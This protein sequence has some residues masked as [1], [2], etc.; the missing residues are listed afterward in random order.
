MILK[1]LYQELRKWL[2]S[3]EGEE[4][5]KHI[6]DT[7]NKIKPLPRGYKVTYKDSWCAT[8]VSFIFYILGIG[9]FPF[10]CSCNLMM[11]AAKKRGLWEENDNYL[12]KPGDCVLYDWRDDGKGDCK[13]NPDHIGIVEHVSLVGMIDV[14]EGNFRDQV[15]RRRISRNGR[16]IRGYIRSSDFLKDTKPKTEIKPT[17]KKITKALIQ[18]V[19]RGEYGVGEERKKKLEAEGYN[20]SKVQE[21]VNEE[22]NHGKK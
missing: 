6:I 7:Y 1:R 13:G 4:N 8:F 10:E 14:V 19:I 17:A 5:H 11:E 12:P 3:K 2:G 22:M 20:Y 18:K 9:E 16:Y 21:K 15:G